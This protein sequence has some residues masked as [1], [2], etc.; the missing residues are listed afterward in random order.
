MEG[1]ALTCPRCGD[2]FDIHLSASGP[3]LSCRCGDRSGAGPTRP[4]R[5][6]VTE[7]LRRR[8]DAITWTLLYGDIAS[9]DLDLA[10]ESLREHVRRTLPDR[11]ALFEM[12][13]VAR[14]RRLRDQGWSREPSSS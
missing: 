9:I 4:R 2:E 3:F 14:W 8:A 12:I 13:W 5:N 10:I 6:R 11:A 1:V 7:D